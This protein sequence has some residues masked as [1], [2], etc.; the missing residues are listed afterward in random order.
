MVFRLKP[1]GP[2]ANEASDALLEQSMK[3]PTQ[4]RVRALYGPRNSLGGSC[5]GFAHSK[6]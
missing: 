5:L 1:R 4:D 3:G 6:T 2:F